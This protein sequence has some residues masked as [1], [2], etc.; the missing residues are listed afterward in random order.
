[1]SIES[2]QHKSH[3]LLAPH[4]DQGSSI[5]E[6]PTDL[7]NVPFDNLSELQGSLS[8]LLGS[9]QEGSP[10]IEI[11][12]IPLNQQTVHALLKKVSLTP[13]HAARKLDSHKKRFPHQAPLLSLFIGAMN[14]VY[15]RDFASGQAMAEKAQQIMHYLVNRPTPELNGYDER[16]NHILTQEILEDT[17]SQVNYELLIGNKSISEQLQE[18]LFG[19]TTKGVIVTSSS[20]ESAMEGKDFTLLVRFLDIV[21]KL[22]NP[23]S[24]NILEDWIYSK[25]VTEPAEMTNFLNTLVQFTTFLDSSA[26]VSLWKTKDNQIPVQP[27]HSLY[28]GVDA[29]LRYFKKVGVEP[30]LE[31]QLSDIRELIIIRYRQIADTITLGSERRLGRATLT[32]DVPSLALRFVNEISEIYPNDPD[33]A[34]EC[35]VRYARNFLEISGLDASEMLDFVDHVHSFNSELAQKILENLIASNLLDVSSVSNRLSSDFADLITTRRIESA[36]N[37]MDRNPWQD[38]ANVDLANVMARVRNNQITQNQGAFQEFETITRD[39]IDPKT[40]TVHK[41]TVHVI[42]PDTQLNLFVI[43]GTFGPTTRGHVSFIESVIRYIEHSE[44]LEDTNGNLINLVLLLPMTRSNNTPG[45]DKEL[46]ETGTSVDRVKTMLMMLSD[47]PKRYRDRILITTALQPRPSVTQSIQGRVHAT[48]NNLVTSQTRKQ[49][50]AGSVLELRQ[51]NVVFCAGFDEVI[52]KRDHKQSFGAIADIQPKKL[53]SGQSL[54]VSRQSGVGNMVA[55]IQ[56]SQKLARLFPEA[57][58]VLVPQTSKT[59]SSEARKKIRAGN[60]HMFPIWMR[61][62]LLKLYSE[63]AIK[64]RRKLRSDE[65]WPVDQIQKQLIDD[66]RETQL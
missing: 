11:S 10:E 40:Q 4:K 51:P 9:L 66:L 7:L 64:K 1:M 55:M 20:S 65:F 22:R 61:E 34:Q 47:L 28:R 58:Y 13:D 46:A 30:D 6:R 57:S 59:S 15:G 23:K 45:Y 63:A 29:A 27:F 37:E 54:L 19:L 42:R 3:I 17:M 5:T 62:L 8:L 33:C 48:I 31:S 56:S 24:A 16:E 36:L 39:V 14:Q 26:Y 25:S 53:T 35:G 43:T 2:Y 21:D 50:R 32:P 12:G 18:G 44:S 38:A 52:R 49:T 41:E 60:T